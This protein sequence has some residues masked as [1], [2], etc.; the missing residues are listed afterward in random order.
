MC[1]NVYSVRLLKMKQKL[2]ILIIILGTIFQILTWTSGH[3]WGGDFSAYIMQAISITEG[4]V[5]KFVELN[6]QTKKFSS[7]PVGPVTY[8]WGLPLLLSTVYTFFG[9]D[10]V[11]F[12]S[13]IL[14]F[15][16]SFL[17]LLWFL[18]EKKLSLFERLIFVS[19]FAFN[20]FLL[21]FGDSILSDIPFLFFS[22]LSIFILFK[23]QDLRSIKS[24]I[25]LS[26]ILGLSFAIGLSLRTNGI[27]LP[28]T[29]MGILCLIFLKKNFKFFNI[30]HINLGSFNYIS[31]KFQ[32]ILVLLTLLIF[33]IT[34]YL[35][36][37]IF[38]NPQDVHV[39]FLNKINLKDIGTN[40]IYYAYIIKD[41]YGP[42][43]IGI[44]LHSISIPFIIIGFL[45]KWQSST[46]ILLYLFLTLSLYILWPFRQGLRFILPIFP[47]YIYF[48]LIGLRTFSNIN[49]K[50]I[51]LFFVSTF[52]LIGCFNIIENFKNNF[53][54]NIGPYTAE[55]KEMFKFLN[56]NVLENETVI[57]RKPRV[58]R[59]FTKKDSVFYN[60]INDF[61]LRDWFVVDKKN[62]IIPISERNKLFDQY[63]VNKNFEN[64]QFII[65]KF[66]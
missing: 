1:L 44:I 2:I 60:N 42:H 12:K 30:F 64:S 13:A 35:I 6:D 53:K 45:K 65:F 7:I 54:L 26:I 24:T 39:N 56:N 22:T 33:L 21:K 63:P 43:F 20:P 57:F 37:L 19:L 16:F 10:I 23:L 46:V 59:L 25:F 32:T 31:K 61:K 66:Q 34:S 58:M 36:F 47:F 27:F 15:F 18:F 40:I 52:I 8:P 55:S 11:I 17:I 9:F 29:Y 5:E 49:K 3:N 48:F 28:I 50:L 38:P 4:N 51:C 41:F 62:V 14:I